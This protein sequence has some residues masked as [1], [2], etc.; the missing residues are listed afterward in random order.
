[1][2]SNNKTTEAIGNFASQI[3]TGSFAYNTKW[4]IYLSANGMTDT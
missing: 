2:H 1:M 4:D 3:Q